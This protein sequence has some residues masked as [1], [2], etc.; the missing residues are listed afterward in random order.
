MQVE[1]VNGYLVVKIPVNSPLVPS[2]TGKTDLVASSG[3]CMKT[4]AVVNGKQVTVNLSAF[5]KR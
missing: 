1:I 2:S 3:G 4:N 5:V